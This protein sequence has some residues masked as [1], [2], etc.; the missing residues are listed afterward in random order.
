MSAGYF[1]RSA[2]GSCLISSPPA[3]WIAKC[4][5]LVQYKSSLLSIYLRIEPVI[6]I[7][8]LILIAAHEKGGH[9]PAL[10]NPEGLMGDL[11]EFAGAH[12]KDRK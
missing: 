1:F 3:A 5:P 2:D 4:G 6:L 7:F 8:L 9:F 10:D 12:W 11:R